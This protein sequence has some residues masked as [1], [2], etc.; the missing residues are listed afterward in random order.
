[1]ESF[2][3]FVL[4]GSPALVVTSSAMGDADSFAILSVEKVTNNGPTVVNARRWS[5]RLN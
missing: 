2:L 3:N 5:Q 4:G 1:L